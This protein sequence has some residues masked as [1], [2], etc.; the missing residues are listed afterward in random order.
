M[1]D[2][3]FIFGSRVES[4]S[5]NPKMGSMSINLNI[6]IDMCMNDIEGTRSRVSGLDLKIFSRS[7]SGRLK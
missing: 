3:K 4:K 6:L 7:G 2:L 1:I 5:K